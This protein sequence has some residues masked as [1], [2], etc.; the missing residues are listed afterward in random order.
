M[1]A[2]DLP[3]T[4]TR[5]AWLCQ[6]STGFGVMA[7]HGL[8]QAV[9]LAFIQERRARTLNYIEAMRFKDYPY[10]S[11]RYSAS[12]PEPTLYSSTYAAMT[13]SLYRD[14]DQLTAMQRAEWIA[15]FQSH[16]DDDGLFRDPRIF[17]EGWYRDDPEW[18]GRRHLSCHVLTALTCL[19][20]VAAKPMRHLEPFYDKAKLTAW[21][22]ARDWSKADFA[23][24]EVLNIG[25]LLQ[26]ARDFQKEKRATGAVRVLIDWLTHHHLDARSGL[27]GSYEV[28]RGDGLSRAVMGAYH[29][30]LLFFYDR[31]PVPHAEAAITHVLRTQGGKDNG[32]GQG[33]HGPR[34]SACEDI[35]SIDPLA[36]L[37]KGSRQ[38][39]EIAKALALA[40][41]HVWNHQN[42]DGG[43]T[44]IRGTKFQYGHPLLDS[45]VN[46]SGMFPTW[47]RSLALAYL[48]RALPASR[49]GTY[50]WHFCQCP[51]I[52][53]FYP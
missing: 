46:G 7:L 41:D 11:F 14:L 35:D 26:Y 4:S 13:R 42:D 6:A 43:F 48:G 27:W 15:Y 34:S 37:L 47:F 1:R 22:E 18:C 49:T 44:W 53:F 8:A 33:V 16:Q 31:V 52:Q 3:F 32:F 39:A 21:L 45:P 38:G 2:L 51:G 9:D 36:R 24:N 20:A 29:F 50:D 12:M 40:E 30:W 10:G 25:T 23:G 17:G 28:S 5:R 19:G